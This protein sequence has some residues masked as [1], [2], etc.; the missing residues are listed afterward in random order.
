[1]KRILILAVLLSSVFSISVFAQALPSTAEV[2][3]SVVN[4]SQENKDAQQVGANNGD[5]LRY[6]ILINSATEDVSDYVATLDLEN[7]LGVTEII[8]TGLGELTETQLSF[9]A[10]S[11]AAPCEKVFTFFVRV[12]PCDGKNSVEVTVN[13][14]TTKVTLNCGLTESGPGFTWKL[15]ILL[16]VGTMLIFGFSFRRKA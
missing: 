9:P 16:A 3:F 6:E 13:G 11:Q 1:M 8:D 7:L 2:T 5:V 4:I 10:F 14:K 12:K 15:M